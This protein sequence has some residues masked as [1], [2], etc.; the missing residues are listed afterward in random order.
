MAAAPP[1]FRLPAV[2]SSPTTAQYAKHALR[3]KPYYTPAFSMTKEQWHKTLLAPWFRKTDPLMPAY[4]HGKN[5]HFPEANY[6]LYG[7]ATLATG[8]RISR[9]RNKG[10]TL[11]KWFPNIRVETVR[12]R[13]LGRDLTIPIRA[14]VMRTI[15]KV[16]GLDQYVLG[17][18]P[19]RIKELGLLG[20]KLRW[21]VMTSPRMKQAYAAERKKLG[22]S[23]N[24]SAIERF[25]HAWNDPERR[26]QMIDEQE[27]AWAK[28]KAKM[29]RYDAHVEA[30]WTASDT[31]YLALE[32]AYTSDKAKR[33]FSLLDTKPSHFAFPDTVEEIPYDQFA[34]LPQLVRDGEATIE[35]LAA[36][37]RAQQADEEKQ[38]VKQWA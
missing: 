2:H 10:K 34:K 22:L 23:D 36:E 15:R 6:G 28:L 33:A 8:H 20:W 19:A 35:S 38:I 5:V 7:G 21:L 27:E 26:Q 29:D 1:V 12:S 24:Y 13:A 4:P 3:H 30:Q 17:S 9:G 16:G 37:Q 32:E 14:R 11:R 25:E 18:R 31:K